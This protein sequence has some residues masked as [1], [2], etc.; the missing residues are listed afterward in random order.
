M[1]PK[2]KIYHNSRKE[3][4]ANKNFLRHCNSLWCNVEQT[5]QGIELQE[6]GE[7]DEKHIAT[8][9]GKNTKNSRCPL[10]PHLRSFRSK[11]K[12]KHFTGKELQRFKGIHHI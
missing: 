9:T 12:Q 10:T 1:S 4:N 11:V 2:T 6:K 5:L 7:K 8:L 3:Y